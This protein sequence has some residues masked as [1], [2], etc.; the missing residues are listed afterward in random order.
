MNLSHAARRP[1]GVGRNS[2]PRSETHGPAQ[3]WIPPAQRAGGMTAK[4]S[5]NDSGRRNSPTADDE[6]RHSLLHRSEG[7]SEWKSTSVDGYSQTP[8]LEGKEAP[9]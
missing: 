3:A 9:I 1:L 5:E 8:R 7:K 4:G 2:R 6:L